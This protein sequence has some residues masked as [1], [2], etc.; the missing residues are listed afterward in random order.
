MEVSDHI[1]SQAALTPGKM[2]PGV[3]WIGDWAALSAD[4][5][6]VEKRKITMICWES[7]PGLPAP[8]HVVIPAMS[9][10]TRR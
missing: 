5:D 2:S 10:F 8:E 7:N 6:A 9:I 4:L 3:H 1:H